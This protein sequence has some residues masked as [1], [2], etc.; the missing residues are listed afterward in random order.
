MKIQFMRFFRLVPVFLG[1]FILFFFLN[2]GFYEEPLWL[3][4][5]A[6]FFALVAVLMF[7]GKIRK[8]W[9]IYFSFVLFVGMVISILFEGVFVAEILGSTGF[10]LI[11]ILLVSYLPRFVKDG[12]LSKW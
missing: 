5:Q 10:G 3:V 9:L 4:L 2:T 7:L 6:A 12:Y 11:I 8:T 1:F